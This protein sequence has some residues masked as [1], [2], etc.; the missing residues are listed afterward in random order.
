MS[1]APVSP[2]PSPDARGSARTA[3]LVFGPPAAV[4]GL[5]WV[6]ELLAARRPPQDA[7]PLVP[8]RVSA[9]WVDGFGGLLWPL[10][11]VAVVTALLVWQRRRAFGPRA[12]P[13]LA[14]A[15]V[16]AGVAAGAALV[17]RHLNVPDLGAAVARPARVLTTQFKPPS[18]RGPGG[19]QLVLQVERLALPQTLLLVDDAR[20][21]GLRPGDA[22][23]LTVA[24]GRWSGQFVTAWQGPGAGPARVAPGTAPAASLP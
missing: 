3:W 6:L 14:V 20:A 13:W 19:S 5:G 23:V 10:V 2:P 12:R 9:G 8:V 17:G 15:W 4:V 24:P 18:P 1:A 11:L 21:A 7:W 16:L 22:L